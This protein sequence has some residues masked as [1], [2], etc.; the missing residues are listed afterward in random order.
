ML[1]RPAF[2][3]IRLKAEY[4]RLKKDRK[5]KNIEHRSRAKPRV[6]WRTMLWGMGSPETAE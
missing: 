1:A 6:L 5:F 4:S 2:K 3:W